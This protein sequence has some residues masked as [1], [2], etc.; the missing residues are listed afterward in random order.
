MEFETVFARIEKMR[1][2]HRANFGPDGEPDI[3]D[4]DQKIEAELAKDPLLIYVAGLF[5]R[6]DIKR[7]QEQ[8]DTARKIQSNRVE[9]NLS[10]L[11]NHA[12]L[13]AEIDAVLAW[14]QTWER[15]EHLTVVDW[16]VLETSLGRRI[17]RDRVKAYLRP[18]S[19]SRD[20]TWA[21]KFV[22]DESVRQAQAAAEERER[23][24][25]DHV[26]S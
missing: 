9:Q 20:D 3:L 19:W 25:H 8:T 6:A 15:D 1:E 26:R 14:A 13:G 10:Q 11:Q 23:Q 22:S 21:K 16:F 17:S 12:Y 24:E 2:A 4:I 7:R 18:P 5:Y